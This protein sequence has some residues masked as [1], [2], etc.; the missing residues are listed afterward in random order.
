ME[1]VG[2]ILARLL[3]IKERQETLDSEAKALWKAFYLIADREAGKEE[4]YRYIDEE[5][6]MVIGR[7]MAV[8]ETIDP[9]KLE[10]ALTHEQWLEVTKSIRSLDQARLEVALDK[11]HIAKDVVEPCVNHRK[12]ARK[13][14][15]KKASKDDIAEIEERQMENAR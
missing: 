4:S 11:G 12:T 9:E 7:T 13:M 3:E 14:G 15:P 2:V 5:T 10:E 8:S 6:R 1:E